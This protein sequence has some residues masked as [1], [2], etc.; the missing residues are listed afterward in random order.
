VLVITA[1]GHAQARSSRNWLQELIFSIA[2]FVI[3]EWLEWLEWH[4]G[5]DLIRVL[6]KTNFFVPFV[7]Y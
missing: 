4:D 6:E 1:D 5:L 7:L 3:D 2:R